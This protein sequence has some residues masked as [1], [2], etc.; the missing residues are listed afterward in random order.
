MIQTKKKKKNHFAFWPKQYKFR[1][2][3]P[4]YPLNKLASID[5]DI[6]A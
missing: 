1:D 2:K 5:V 6:K 4:L 3:A